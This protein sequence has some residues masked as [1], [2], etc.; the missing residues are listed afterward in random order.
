MILL[1]TAAAYYYFNWQYFLMAGKLRQMP[2]LRVWFVPIS[3]AVSYLFFIFC[4]ILEFP[5]I[6]NWFLF[7]FLLFFETLFYSKGAGRCALFSTPVSYT[8]LTL[9]TIA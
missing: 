8:H 5:L 3:F 4:S 1:L 7:A 9:P 2:V 6:V